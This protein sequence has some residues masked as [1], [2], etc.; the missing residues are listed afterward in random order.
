ML[1]ASCE[2]V[3]VRGPD[4]VGRRGWAALV[5]TARWTP[6][7]ETRVLARQDSAYRSTMREFRA[8]EAIVILDGQLQPLD[9]V[10]LAPDRR[11][12]SVEIEEPVGDA[13]EE[14]GQVVLE[15]LVVVAVLDIL[16]HAA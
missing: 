3:G 4:G 13:V 6:E 10:D 12:A 14:D 5:S 9:L 1:G 2:S 8:T 11:R 15:Q 16:D 7:A